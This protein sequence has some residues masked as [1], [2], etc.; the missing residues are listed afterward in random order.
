M[1]SPNDHISRDHY[2][3][4]GEDQGGLLHP[5]DALKILKTCGVVFKTLVSD[6][7]L[8][9]PKFIQKSKLNLKLRNMVLRSLPQ[10]LFDG[11][12]C[13]F[14]NGMVTKDC[15]FYQL[16]KE[17]I[18]KFMKTRL[19]RYGQYFAEMT[20]KKGNLESGRN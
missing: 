9:N 18:D 1:I 19:L 10:R 3:I 13:S 16:K 11:I 15:H 4:F 5:S 2:L 17:I 7:D 8:Q 12:P 6:E 20:R 14:N